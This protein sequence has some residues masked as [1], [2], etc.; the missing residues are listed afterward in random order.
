MWQPSELT[1]GARLDQV[2]G[3]ARATVRHSNCPGLC[4]SP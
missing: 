1:R 2:V 4:A 3:R